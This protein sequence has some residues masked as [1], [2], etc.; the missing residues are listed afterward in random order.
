VAA[1]RHAFTE[2]RQVVHEVTER[3]FRGGRQRGGRCVEF[4]LDARAVEV[5]PIC[6]GFIGPGNSLAG[7]GLISKRFRVRASACRQTAIGRDVRIV[8]KLDIVHLALHVPPALG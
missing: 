5:R 1:L 2:S 7:E 6:I 8:V 3:G 4:A